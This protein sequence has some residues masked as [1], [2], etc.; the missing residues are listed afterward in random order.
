MLTRTRAILGALLLIASSLTSSIAFSSDT[1][2]AKSIIECE[3]QYSI[4]GGCEQTCGKPSGASS[5]SSQAAA[6]GGGGGGCGGTAEENKKQ[7]WSFLLSKGLSE[8]AAA[9]IMGNMEQESGFM[10]TADNG[11]TMGFSDSTGNGCRGVVQWCHERNFGTGGDGKHSLETFAE[12]KGTEWHCLGTQ[13]EYMWY[14]MTETK[15]GNHSGGGDE[16]EIPLADALNGA[17]FSR[18][19]NYTNSEAYNAAAIF[20]D[21]F[22]RAN[23]AKGENL[24]RGE[25]A[26]EIYTEFTGTAPETLG[27]A[28]GKSKCPSS[29]GGIPQ[30]DCKELIEKMNSL[31]GTAI[32]HEG[33]WVQQDVDACTP[34]EIPRCT[35]PAVNPPV[36]R[37]IIAMAEN[38]GAGSVLVWNINHIHGCDQFDHPIGL[39]TDIGGCGGQPA[40]TTNPEPC[41]QV[42]D[43]LIANKDALGVKYVIWNG[44]YCT[45]KESGYSGGV[46]CNGDHSDHI[47]V[48][49]NFEGDAGAGEGPSDL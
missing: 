42:F 11:K 3:Q 44:S 14:E 40:D 49:F 5:K 28:S 7:I 12:E 2:F 9:G 24:G 8:S 19:S 13:L 29:S 37:G 20:H 16:L 46:M 17:E 48:S 34:E 41:K 22:E 47:H 31:K 6:G 1:S 35:S 39:A 18:K 21:Y 23:T 25:R 27:T 30:G 15:R 26:D 45:S 38:S 32:E 4:Y 43:Y 10:P 36:L 33:D